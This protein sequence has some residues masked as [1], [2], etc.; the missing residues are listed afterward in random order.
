MITDIGKK[1]LENYN[2]CKVTLGAHRA[3]VVTEVYK[4]TD[5]MS[6]IIRQAIAFARVL[7][8]MN[9]YIQENELLVG[10]S[11]ER[12]KCAEIFPEYSN[13]YIDELDTISERQ[14]DPYF[15][16]NENKE[17]LKKCF[18]YWKGK[19]LHDRINKA[20][21]AEVKKAE[22]SG[23]ISGEMINKASPGHL[24][25]DFETIINKGLKSMKK[26]VEHHLSNLK[27]WESEEVAKRDNLRGML[28]ACEAIIKF[29]ERYANLARE[30]AAKEIDDRRKKELEEI[31]RVCARLAENPAETFWEALQLILFIYFAEH[32]ESSGYSI[33][34]GRMDQY[35]YSFYKKDIEEGRL[36]EKRA[37]ELLECFWIKLAEVNKVMDELTARDFEGYQIFA[38]ITLGGQTP[39]GRDATNEL[40]YLMLD[41]T[42]DLKINKPSP[43]VRIHSGT[44]DDFL[45][46]AC[47]AN[48][49]YKGGQPAF[50]NDELV[51]PTLLAFQSDLK[52]EDA[53]N[54][55]VLGCVEPSILGGGF[56]PNAF[57]LHYSFPK[58]LEITLYGGKDPNTGYQFHS[59]DGDLSSWNSFDEVM[60]AW[61]EKTKYFNKLTAILNNIIHSEYEKFLPFPLSSLLT[62]GCVEKGCSI[63]KNGIIKGHGAHILVGPATL[64]DSLASIK[65]N[66]FEEKRFTGAQLL[67]ALKANFEG[68]SGKEIQRWCKSAPKF[69]NDDDYVDEIVK[70][71]LSFQ[72][73]DMH[74]YKTPDGGMF[75]SNIVPATAHLGFGR[76]VGATPDGRERGVPLS[77]ALSPAQGTD[78]KGPTAVI[79]SVAKI[80]HSDYIQG[81]VLNLKLNLKKENLKIL[82]GLI[83]AFVAL[84]AH[85]VQINIMTNEE[86]KEAQLFPEKHKDLL[87]RIAGYSAR[88]V[89]L[90]KRTQDDIIER[91][92]HSI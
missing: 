28:I 72:A 49:E 24:I 69:G 1:L 11:G 27:L 58:V 42:K 55:S 56:V 83:K 47:E 75:G 52:K 21:P 9:I 26:N 90:A 22:E 77:D 89:D 54:W 17:E 38:N 33:S 81:T 61:K 57:A 67:D 91:T 25:P 23:V 19:T 3:K 15:I 18:E 59:S 41:I 71:T 6:P 14:W 12:S 29:V 68:S 51:I 76:A 70:M 78:M 40:S 84:K 46:K 31:A 53:R 74:K 60:E 64:G 34:L 2:N 35:L 62:R 13:W 30:E 50:L 4:Q 20:L 7:E 37:R 36:S 87:V 73:K 79:K 8:K 92:E 88:F 32:V 63:L 43:S 65:K 85:E 80:D 48:F 39:D 10:N 86:L 66:I 5:G 44:S 45:L 16:S 82:V